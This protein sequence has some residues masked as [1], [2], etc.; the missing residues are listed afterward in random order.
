MLDRKAALLSCREGQ[1][2]RTAGM[3][4]LMLNAKLSPETTLVVYQ[5]IDER[6]EPT[7][8][9]ESGRHQLHDAEWT[10]VVVEEG[11]HLGVLCVLESKAA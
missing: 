6:I 10:R 2:I 1:W 11:P 5:L 9:N 8:V 3:K 4:R 7:W